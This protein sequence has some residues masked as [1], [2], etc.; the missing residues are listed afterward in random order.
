MVDR[1]QIA[2]RKFQDLKCWLGQVFRF[3]FIFVFFKLLELGFRWSDSIKSELT[4]PSKSWVG[5]ALNDVLFFR[6][7]V[8]ESN[9]CLAV[10]GTA[11]HSEQRPFSVARN[12]RTR[13]RVPDVVVGVIKLFFGE[14]LL[15]VDR[16]VKKNRQDNDVDS[17]L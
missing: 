3:A 13:H 15:S 2:C 6:I 7:E 12:S 4:V 16:T 10:D 5:T 8:A 11:L 17:K 14:V 1:R 9:R